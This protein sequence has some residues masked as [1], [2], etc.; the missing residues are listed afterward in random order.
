MRRA[1]IAGLLLALLAG[2]LV[3]PADAAKRKP[4]KVTRQAQATYGSPAPIS[5]STA[6]GCWEVGES[7]C[8]IFPISATERWVTM[9]VVDDASSAPVAF[10]IVQEDE[11]TGIRGGPF[12]GSTGEDPVEVTPGVEVGVMIYTSGDVVCPSAVATTGTV[13]AVFSNLP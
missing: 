4:K 13:K 2:T 8:P 7:L 1:W 12:C 3:T 9:E 6:G 5:P 11:Q 10:S